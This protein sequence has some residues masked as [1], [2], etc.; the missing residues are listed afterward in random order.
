MTRRSWR[1]L[2]RSD[3]RVF[4]DVP[5]TAACEGVS[6]CGRHENGPLL[7][8]QDRLPESHAILTTKPYALATT[9]VREAEK[10]NIFHH[11][12]GVW[13]GGC[14]PWSVDTR[15]GA[16]AAFGQLD[17]KLR[18][19]ATT[20]LTNDTGGGRNR[21]STWSAVPIRLDD[22]HE[23]PGPPRRPDRSRSGLF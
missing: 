15:A 2:L 9:I 13:R 4:C 10:R 6:E 8:K 11:A 12:G 21:P 18:R 19:T 7:A 20:D 14:R 3:W 17:P 23:G 5:L 1:N 16:L 22:D